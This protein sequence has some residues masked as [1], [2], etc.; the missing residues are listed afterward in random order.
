M[1]IELGNELGN[2]ATFRSFAGLN[3]A[4]SMAEATGIADT[5]AAWFYNMKAH[6][7]WKDPAA[8]R[9]DRTAPSFSKTE[10][11][12][13]DFDLSIDRYKKIVYKEIEYEA[14]EEL[15]DRIAEL[16]QGIASGIEGLLE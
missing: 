12:K 13:N 15:L 4:R 6:S 11:P 8:A 7:H 2:T 3:I 14:T 10:S 16:E 9:R 5:D 1:I